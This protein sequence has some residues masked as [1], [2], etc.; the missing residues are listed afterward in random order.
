MLFMSATLDESFL[1][2]PLNSGNLHTMSSS[3][4]D[5]SPSAD[6]IASSLTKTTGTSVPSATRA[7][8]VRVAAS[9]TKAGDSSH[10][11]TRASA[12]TSLPSA[13]VFP[14]SLVKPLRAVSTSP[15]RKALAEI[16]FSTAEMITTRF[17]LSLADMIMCARPR[18]IA[19]PPISFFIWRIPAAGLMSRPPVS[20][21][22]PF[23]TSTTVG[24]DASPH[25]ILMTRGAC[26]PGA[27]PRPT[28]C[29]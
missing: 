7:A 9:I 20:N 29:T 19:D 28:A 8:P 25:V 12:R 24:S 2:Y 1:A 21:V 22:T 6:A 4:A 26:F 5:S 16:A 3:I 27:A 15:G 13:S 10:A 11:C 14:I 17:T 18:T 23:P